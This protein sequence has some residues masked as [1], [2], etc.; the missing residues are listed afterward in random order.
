MPNGGNPAQPAKPR[1]LDK[2]ALER[3]DQVADAVDMAAKTGQLSRLNKQ[4]KEAHR[5][6]VIE[7]LMEV[8]KA[9]LLSGIP[10]L[11][12]NILSPAVQTI[13]QPVAKTLGAMV[14]GNPQ[15]AKEGF[16]LLYQTVSALGDI[17]NATIHSGDNGGTKGLRTVMD[18]AR[19][20]QPGLTG[21]AGAMEHRHAITAESYGLSNESVRGRVVNKIGRFVRLPFTASAMSE[22]IFNQVSYLAYVRTKALTEADR[23][24]ADVAVPDVDKP[25]MVAKFVDSYTKAAF[26]N[27]GRAAMDGPNFKH[28]DAIR[29]AKSINF[30]TEL[31]KGTIGDSLMKMKAQHPILDLVIPFV[32][33]PTNLLRTT[34]RYTP[35]LGQLQ[36]G[37]LRRVLSKNPDEVLRARGEMVMGAALWGTAAY[38]AAS[39]QITGGGPVNKGERDALMATGWRPYAFVSKDEQGRTVYTE[40]RRFDP[41]ASIF[42]MAADFTEVGAYLAEDDRDSFAAAA[43]MSVANNLTSKTYLQGISDVA[44]ALTGGTNGAS[45]LRSKVA[46]FVP[47]ILARS[48]GADD[49][50]MRE[51]RTTM[52]AIK[53]RIPGYS[54]TLAPRRDLLGS[55]MTPPAGLLPFTDPTQTGPMQSF[56]RMASPVNV[57]VRTSDAVANEMAALKHGF[58]PPARKMNGIDLTL[59]KNRNGQDAYD[60]L[61]ELTG[62][63][64]IG[65]KDVHAAL[66]EL[67]RSDYYKRLPA[68][69]GRNDNDNA[70][71]RAMTKVLSRYR[72]AARLQVM[73]EFPEL[74]AAATG[75]GRPTLTSRDNPI[76]QALNR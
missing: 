37:Y 48:A 68:P 12:L 16:R 74:K 28:E 32:R 13:A 71:I 54:E 19:T 40:F 35:L 30:T 64:K 56:A 24:W 55:P 29:Y 47:N 53:R 57:G 67:V 70:R 44:R 26:D 14:S 7:T 3:L 69:E 66:D 60:R 20:E 46:S 36:E 1:K 10:T 62:E 34:I 2:A 72:Q 6:G 17:V 76:L 39:G 51:V 61:M 49:P 27:F 23:I 58:S 73:R 4:I 41:M 45:V 11:V 63:I 8:Q 5:A 21:A 22:E 15:G 43:V 52:D 59:L 38:M 25:A 31:G 65:S 42:G 33:V 50:Y 75:Q 9:S 18:V